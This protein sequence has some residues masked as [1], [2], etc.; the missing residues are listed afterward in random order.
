MAKKTYNPFKMIGSWVGVAIAAVI[1][2][3][4]IIPL[5]NSLHISQCSLSL[6]ACLFPATMNSFHVIYILGLLY[7]VLGFLAGWGIHSLIRVARK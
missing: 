3:F 4:T 1:G 6:L 7:I 5:Y 2:Y